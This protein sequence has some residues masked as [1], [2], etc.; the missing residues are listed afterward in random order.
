M[1]LRPEN[2]LKQKTVKGLFWGGISNGV[3]QLLSVVIGLIFLKNLSP[4]DYGMIE[5]LA[6][7]M[8]VASIIQDSGFTM[9]LANK[10]TFQNKDF[11][12]VFWFNLIVGCSIYIILYFCAPLI[13]DFYNQP[14]LVLL[15]R[16]LFLSIVIGS[17]STAHNAVLF[18]LLLVRERAKIDI[19]STLMGGGIGVYMALSGYGY[20]ALAIQT[21]VTATV[22]MILR[23]YYSPWRPNFEIDFRPIK[24]MFG[25]SSRMLIS[26][27]VSQVQANIFSVLLGKYNTT[28]DVGN[29][30]QGVKWSRMGG[31]VINGMV[32][33]VA[34]PIFVQLQGEPKRFALIF[35][36]MIRFIAFI[37]FPAMLGLAFVGREFFGLINEDWLPSV[38]ILQCYC[39]WAAFSPISLLYTQVVISYGRSNCFFINGLLFAVIQI[40]AAILALPFGI[41]WMAFVNVVVSC[42]YILV[43]HR[44]VSKLIPVTLFQIVKDFSPYLGLTLIIF[45]IVWCFLR[46]ID[47]QNDALIFVVKILLSAAL[48]IGALMKFNSVI[49]R[50]SLIFMKRRK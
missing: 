32:S 31:Q 39:I 30:S 24:E 11:N 9:A 45:A 37:S 8:G 19:L 44:I 15:S 49:F 41:Y 26:S 18:K 1:E 28:S 5:L 12:A 27:V 13:A 25:F 17:L 33:N 22:G 23:W 43:W 2:T 14:E 36:K 47:L 20:W 7:F 35:R 6:I 38:P 29:F 40:G 50:E 42:F 48:Y 10:P 46:I 4:G 21:L 16:I 34:Q 3:Q